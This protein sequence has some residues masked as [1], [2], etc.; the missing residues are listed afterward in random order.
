M[1]T[2]KNNLLKKKYNI[3][4][5]LL[6]FLFCSGRSDLEPYYYLINKAERYIVEKKFEEAL[7]IYEKAFKNYDSPRG[8]DYYNAALTALYAGKENRAFKF[9]LETVKR[10]YTL[11]FINNP[12]VNQLITDKNKW[13]LFNEKCDSLQIIYKKESSTPIVKELRTMQDEEQVFTFNIYSDSSLQL[14]LDSLYLDNMVRIVELVQKDSLP[15]VECFNMNS[16]TLQS[17]LPFII[18][19][20]YFGMYNRALHYP[21]EH[22]DKL[23]EQVINYNPIVEKNLLKLIREGKLS[24][25]FILEAITYNNPNNLFGKQDYTYCRYIT[26]KKNEDIMVELVLC[27]EDFSKEKV[28]TFNMYREKWFLPKY[29]IAVKYTKDLNN[30]PASITNFTAE[31]FNYN[32]DIKTKGYFITDYDSL[33]FTKYCRDTVGANPNIKLEWIYLGPNSGWKLPK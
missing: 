23:Y 19:R 7:P 20:H 32:G 18:I 33:Q 27:F 12:V 6:F 8:N 16:R 11:D 1:L 14:K 25:E 3:I 28:D 26:N 2:V 10:G 9:L 29:N 15:L 21:D 4:C 24:P 13:I 30:L 22:K 5:I 17:I 31:Y